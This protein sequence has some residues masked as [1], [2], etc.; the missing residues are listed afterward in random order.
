MDEFSE[1]YCAGW[2]LDRGA[3]PYLYEPLRTC[4]HRFNIRQ[5]FRGKLFAT[6]PAV[7]IPAPQPPYDFAPFMA[8]ANARFSTGRAID[9]LAI[10]AAVALC[11]IALAALGVPLALAAAVFV[12]SA[13]Y[14]ELNTA[15]I[16]PF[17]LLALVLAG[18]TLARGRDGL[19]GVC[20]ALTA[21]EPTMGLPVILATFCFARRARPSLAVT[22]F[23]LLGLACA[24]AGP[25][26]VVDY[27][28]TVLPAHAQSEL[29]FPYQYSLT[30]AIAALGAPSQVARLAGLASYAVLVATALVIAPRASARLQG[31]ELIVFVPALCSV[32]GGSFLHQE[33]LCFAIPAVTLLA[34][35]TTGAQRTICAVALAILAVPWIPV[36]GAKQLLL[37]SLFIVAT[38]LAQLRVPLRAA[39]LA[40]CAIAAVIYCFEL[41]P[42]HLSTPS[43]MPAIYGANDLVSREWRDYTERRA[44]NDPLWY[45]I[46]LPVW[47]ALLAALVVA[48]RRARRDDQPKAA[49]AALTP[50]ISRRN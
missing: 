4:E 18:L 3:S 39:L 45:A 21:I 28:T 30:Y 16:V 9:A 40:F 19:A 8:L 29:H 6:L 17:A 14:V 23:G 1:F 20:A 10:V 7:A 2:V 44:S 49:S 12:L 50:S 37:P 25:K 41:S 33:E 46:K 36:W 47:G 34:W 15:Q 31:R 35:R 22:L 26:G 43:S 38:I 42:P 48:A 24:V 27:L 32:I 5:S 11:A 13:G